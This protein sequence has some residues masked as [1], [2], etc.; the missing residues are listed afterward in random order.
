M[1]LVA[2]F[3]VPGHLDVVEEGYSLVLAWE[4][5]V[6]EGEG[7]EEEQSVDHSFVLVSPSSSS[8]QG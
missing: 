4:L 2:L 1:R 7:Q 5:E 3:E 8:W 6:V